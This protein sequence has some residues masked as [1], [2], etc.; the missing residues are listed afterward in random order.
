MHAG[1][2]PPQVA[3]GCVLMY[4][5]AELN[6][7]C[8][9]WVSGWRFGTVCS[10]STTAGTSK[11]GDPAGTELQMAP[12]PDEAV[13]PLKRAWV[14][15]GESSEAP[16]VHARCIVFELCSPEDNIAKRTYASF[17]F[18][19]L[20]GLRC[21]CSRLLL[22]LQHWSRVANRVRQ[23]P[24]CCIQALLEERHGGEVLCLSLIHI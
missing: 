3:E 5:V 12:W 24:A 20:N 17:C 10:T 19:S 6:P 4:K 23:G 22:L 13:H 1:A 2:L 18:M 7:A 16:Q 8:M 14:A 9:P 15:L 21:C 11:A